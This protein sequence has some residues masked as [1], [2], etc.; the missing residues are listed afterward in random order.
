MNEVLTAAALTDEALAFAL[1]YRRSTR[2]TGAAQ[3]RWLAALEAEAV[4]RGLS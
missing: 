3:K 1:K 2:Q 4:K